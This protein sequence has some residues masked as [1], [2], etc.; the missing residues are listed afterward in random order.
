M[1]LTSGRWRDGE[2]MKLLLLFSNLLI[3]L[4]SLISQ[5]V[6]LVTLALMFDTWKIISGRLKFESQF[7]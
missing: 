4:V 7:S 2:V 1:T 6:A 5:T 3:L